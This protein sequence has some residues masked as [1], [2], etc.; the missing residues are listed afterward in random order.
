MGIPPLAETT[1][2]PVP[3][4]LVPVTG[5]AKSTM[6]PAGT[7]SVSAATIPARPGGATLTETGRLPGL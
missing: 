7:S 4:P 3:R 5:V 1:T 2:E 6:P